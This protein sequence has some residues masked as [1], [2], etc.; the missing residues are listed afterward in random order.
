M[1][2]VENEPII[3]ACCTHLW[4]RGQPSVVRVRISD[5]LGSKLKVGTDVI[6]QD[7]SNCGHK[8]EGV[9]VEY[10]PDY[11]CPF[12]KPTKALVVKDGELRE[13]QTPVFRD[14]NDKVL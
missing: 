3:T 13:C 6:C 9:R 1:G 5:G 12:I 11:S 2:F 7:T 4:D 8:C 14:L 10:H